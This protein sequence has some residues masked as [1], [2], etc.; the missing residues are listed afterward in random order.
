MKIITK[1]FFASALMF[2][3]AAPTLSHAAYFVDQTKTWATNTP[4]APAGRQ[5]H[6]DRALDAMA[7]VPA[8][9]NFGNEYFQKGGIINQH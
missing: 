9:G 6:V 3:A 8:E 2:A 1:V 5:V 7:Y 4:A